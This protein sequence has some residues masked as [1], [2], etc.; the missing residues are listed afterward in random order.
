[1]AKNIHLTLVFYCPS[2]AHSIKNALTSLEDRLK[3]AKKSAYSDLSME[4]SILSLFSDQHVDELP[5]AT[6]GGMAEGL[7][8]KQGYWLRADPIYIRLTHNSAYFMGYDDLNLKSD[9]VKHLIASLNPFLAQDHMKLYA[10][11]ADQ[12]YLHCQQRPEIMTHAPSEVIGK[13][14]YEYLPKGTEKRRWRH[15]FTEIQM[16]LHHQQVNVKRKSLGQLEM[17]GLWFWGCGQ[18]P[19]KIE[20]NWSKVWTDVPWVQA[21][22]DHFKLSSWDECKNIEQ[23]LEK[24]DNSGQ[25]LII[26]QLEPGDYESCL[27]QACNAG[28]EWVNKKRA[29]Q[30]TIYP[31]DGYKYYLKKRWF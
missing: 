21:L 14:I 27:K 22:V 31:G 23:C 5:I 20:E 17:N 16:L 18:L 13:D 12:W 1:M 9:E 26:K 28:I 10:P 4:R 30:L 11:H 15:L 19:E 29:R 25:Y 6:L 8:T 3:K 7:N 24:M 2:F